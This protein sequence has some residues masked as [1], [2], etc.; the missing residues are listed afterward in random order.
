MGAEPVP[1]FAGLARAAH[2]G[3]AGLPIPFPASEL[4]ELVFQDFG[5]GQ[6]IANVVERV[7]LHARGKR[8]ALAWN[9]PQGRSFVVM[10][11]G[12]F[13]IYFAVV[14]GGCVRLPDSVAVPVNCAV[15]GGAGGN[16]A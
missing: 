15:S 12:S 11:R 13:V 4:L 2:H 14:R 16:E 5:E 10:I 3:V 8:A 7:F 6:K 9:R 1:G